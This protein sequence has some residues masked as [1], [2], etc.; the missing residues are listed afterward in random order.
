MAPPVSAARPAKAN[1]DNH[2]LTGFDCLVL[3]QG[4]RAVM[5]ACHDPSFFLHLKV[6]R[7]D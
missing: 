7:I 5:S 2:G 1:T 3:M 4:C 6:D